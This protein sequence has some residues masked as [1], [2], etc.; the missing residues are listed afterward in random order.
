MAFDW[1]TASTNARTELYRA[2]KRVVD[3]HYVGDWPKFMNVVFDGKFAAGIG[4]LD[5]FRTGRIGR[6]KA[7][8]LA[9]WLSIHHTQ[10]A[11]LLAARIAALDDVSPCAWDELCTERAERG[12]LSITRL[13]DL[14]IVGFAH[15]K[16]EMAVRLR[17]GEEFCLRFDSPHQGHAFAMQ[18]VRGAW[19]V[20]P[21]SPT[22]SIVSISKGIVTL[23]RDEQDGTVIP[24]ADHEDGGKVGFIMAVSISPFPDDLIDRLAIDGAFDRPTLDGI[25]R[26][27]AASDNVALHEAN[28][29]II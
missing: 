5:N 25:A 14:A 10:E 26:S 27:I 7:A 6:P 20:L 28:A 3:G 1:L 22:C 19:H 11:S 8:A 18:C 4:F 29:L 13:N 12:R 23:P 21:L 15:T 9:R 16:A 24:L 17:L 2:C